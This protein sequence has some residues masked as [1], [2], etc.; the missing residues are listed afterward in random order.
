MPA[1]HGMGVIVARHGGP[2]VDPDVVAPTVSADY[3]EIVRGFLRGHIPALAG[4]SIGRTEVCLYTV[5]PGDH[6]QVDFLPDRPDVI[7]ASPCSGHGFKFSC[8][9]GRILAD[10]ALTGESGLELESWKLR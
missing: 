9:I 10:L 4:A 3:V 6:F 8:L 2:E 1:V 5:A 7:V